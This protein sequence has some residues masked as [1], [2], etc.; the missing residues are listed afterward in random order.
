MSRPQ[1]VVS[2][3]MMLSSKAPSAR[4]ACGFADD[5]IHRLASHL[6][7]NG[8]DRAEGATLVAAFAHAQIGPVT[9]RQSKPRAIALEVADALAVLAMH[10]QFGRVDTAITS[11]LK[12]IAGD[13]VLGL[14][15]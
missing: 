2:W 10:R 9:G 15:R 5:V 3:P 11:G 6:A 12:G 4:R 7:A 8:W 13:P 14:V 1:L